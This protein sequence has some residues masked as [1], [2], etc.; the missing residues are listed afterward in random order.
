MKKNIKVFASH[1][2]FGSDR[3]LAVKRAK[4]VI[5]LRYWGR[6]GIYESKMSRILYL[7]SNKAFIISEYFAVEDEDTRKFCLT[8][9]MEGGLDPLRGVQ[10]EQKR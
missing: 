1:W 10:G 4:I 9:G 5:N 6:P 7:L 2:L 8:I 3:D